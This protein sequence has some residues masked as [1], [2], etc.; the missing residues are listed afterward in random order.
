MNISQI[1]YFLE[2]AR[3]QNISEAAKHLYMTQ[4]ALGRQLTAIEKELNMQ[5]MIRNNKGIKL[6]PAGS[7]LFEEFSQV[8]ERYKNGIEKAIRISHGFSGTLS[9][10]I[11]DGLKIDRLI[12]DA[13]D[14][15]EQNYPNVEI[16]IQ[17]FSFHGLLNGLLH[18]TLDAAISLDFNF[19]E[20]PELQKKNLTTYHPAFAVPVK[21]PLARKK[22]L[23]FKD[24]KDIPLVIVNHEDCDAG[25]HKIIQLF[26]I[27]GGFYPRFHFTPTMKDAMLWVEAGRKC[28]VLNMEMQAADSPLVKMYPLNA[29]ETSY[30][31]LAARSDTLNYAVRLL[32]EFY[33]HA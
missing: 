4:P 26:Q 18:N 22:S 2:T 16:S 21:H 17:R 6:T 1:Q 30:I 23:D 15:F 10:G 7:I 3:C 13:L 8:L 31:Q 29:P 24:F 5:L 12:P 11:L 19:P 32:F 33:S 14:Y 25:V 28:A 27:N 20:D 9:I